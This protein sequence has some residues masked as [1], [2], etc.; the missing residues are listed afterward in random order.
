MFVACSFCYVTAQVEEHIFLNFHIALW[1][2]A[3]WNNK[4]SFFLL[5]VEKSPFCNLMKMIIKRILD[6]AFFFYL[7]MAFVVIFWTL[8]PDLWLSSEHDYKRKVKAFLE[9][10][11]ISVNQSLE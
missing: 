3:L 6:V 4:F 1:C 9:M 8:K 5:P 2:M 7:C 10:N 11:I